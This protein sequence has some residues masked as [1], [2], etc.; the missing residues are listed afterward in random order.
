MRWIVTMV[1]VGSGVVAG[2]AIAGGTIQT[3]DLTAELSADGRRMS[4]GG[5]LTC[6]AGERITLR[7]RVTQ[8]QTGALGTGSFVD[9]CTGE[10]GRWEVPRLKAI[11]RNRFRAGAAEGCAI[12]LTRRGDRVTD[13]HQWCAKGG[14]ALRRAAAR[15]AGG[16]LQTIDRKVILRADGRTLVVSG[17]VACTRGERVTVDARVTQRLTGALAEGR[18]HAT[19]TGEKQTWR[20]RR[21]VTKH[22]ERFGPGEAEACGLLLTRRRGRVTDA[23]QW[24]RESGVTIVEEDAGGGRY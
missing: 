20:V 10:A 17:P 18:W 2:A 7:A 23:H 3:F 5:P 12:A 24:C 4:I 16:T 8:R 6:D 21:A 1:V 19:C 22:R 13:A 9:T 14:I 11:G 15:A